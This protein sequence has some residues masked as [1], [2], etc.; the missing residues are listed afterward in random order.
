[1]F[2][3][4]EGKLYY[5]FDDEQVCIEAWG[6]NALR[7]RASKNF[8]FTGMDWAL[9]G[10]KPHPAE[11][12]IWRDENAEGGA[13]ANMYE[14]TD[15]SFGKIVNGKL[16]AE[17]DSGGVLS[18]YG[19]GGELLLK[20]HFRRLRDEK[21]M[22]LNIL[23]REYRHCS[24]ENY[25]ITARFVANPKEKIFGMGQYQQSE[26]DMKGCLLELAQ[27][28]SQVSVP[29]Y[30]SS[31]GYGF[32][33]NNPAVGQVM[34]AKN[35]TEWIARSA[36][37]LDY[38]VIAGDCPAEI[39]E[40]YMR[41]TGL[42]P[43][44][45]E[46]GMGFWQCK[47]RYRTQEELLKVARHHK[48]LGLPMD[49]IVADFFHW[50][51]QGEF[52]FDEKYWPDVPAMCSELEEMGIRLMVSIWPTIDVH[53]RYYQEMLEKGYLVRTDA[54]VRITM[55]CGGNE[56]F[57]DAT[58]P[59]A[60]EFVW[61]KVKKNYWDQG[62]RLYWL[63]VAEPE[64]TTYEFENYRYQ[65]GSTLETG[66][67]YPKYY[68]K[69]FYDGMTAL[70]EEK[71]ITLIRSAWAGS[72]KYGALVWS[73]DIVSS[74]ECFGRQVRAGLSMAI[75]GIPWWTTDIG[76]F[77][78]AR[79]DDPAF[80]ELYARWFAYACFCPVMRLHGNR[81]PQLDFGEDVIGTGSDNEV[82]SFGEKNL[83]ISR[84]YIFLREKLRDYLREQMQRAH[85]KGTP[86]MR[87][88]FYDF[89][90]DKE[91]WEVDDAYLF[92]PDLY[93]APVLEEGARERR[94]YLP[95][96]KNWIDVWR[97]TEYKGGTWV[98]V[99]A[100][101]EQIPVFGVKGAEVLKVFQE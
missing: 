64:Y 95:E 87:P 24:G 78:G 32:L 60:R 70:G 94:V 59:K 41:L 55:L 73:G 10:G 71:P 67:I 1:M 13:Y 58:N 68:L 45:P 77:H 83:E 54:G 11:V 43:M 72:A 36:K 101:I 34:F 80:R 18:F 65:I 8:C 51:C 4:R 39:Q 46:Y 35:G 16:R 81:N 28:N 69:G 25:Q 96:G 92:G 88:A 99:P 44:M 9:E 15:G 49:V 37:E 21:S 38:V 31:L 97:G 75:A 47:L 3:S 89:P 33:W 86:V 76:G 85:E 26:M 56:V 63:D 19:E 30:L 40:E 91:C 20:E 90:L 93:V 82:W 23:G 29:F 27:R 74:F 2:E 14:G 7:I 98:T 12:E 61:E 66:N 53:S 84:F 42:P 48:A 17:I 62:A 50:P 52:C 22:P 5:R 100:P 57:F 79:G 6:D